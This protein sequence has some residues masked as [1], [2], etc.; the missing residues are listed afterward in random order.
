[1]HNS[2]SGSHFYKLRAASC[3]CKNSAHRL[4]RTRRFG[5][6]NVD[7]GEG[8]RSSSNGTRENVRRPAV[9][10]QLLTGQTVGSD[11]SYFSRR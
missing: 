3:I 4:G 11:H 9:D 1:V 8:D 5:A 10:R 6:G 2:D 7:L